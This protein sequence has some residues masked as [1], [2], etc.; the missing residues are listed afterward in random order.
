MNTVHVSLDD[1]KGDFLNTKTTRKK[2]PAQKKIN[3]SAIIILNKPS[4]NKIGLV[5]INKIPYNKKTICFK[6]Y[7]YNLLDY[8]D[9]VDS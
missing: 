6:K 5:L 8:V 7:H 2:L 1:L 3:T 9:T 4:K